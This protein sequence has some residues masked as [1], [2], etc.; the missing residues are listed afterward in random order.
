M[1]YLNSVIEPGEAVGIVASQ[2]VGEPST[3]MTL[4]TFHL[5]GHSGKRYPPPESP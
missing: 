4:N 1:K 5:A 2:S 3:Q